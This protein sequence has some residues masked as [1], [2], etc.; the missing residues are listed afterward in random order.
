MKRTIAVL[1]FAAVLA[2]TAFAQPGIANAKAIYCSDCCHQKCD[3]KTCCKGSCN[4][5]CCQSK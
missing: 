1:S 5:S 3:G 4:E 2:A